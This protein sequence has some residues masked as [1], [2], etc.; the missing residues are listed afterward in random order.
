MDIGIIL[1]IVGAFLTLGLS[2]NAFFLKGIYTKQLEIELKVTRLIV[3]DEEYSR[4]Y[5][6]IEDVIKLLRERTHDNANAILVLRNQ[7]NQKGY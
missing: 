5:N 7:L 3:K 4:K 2:V 6:N 1:A